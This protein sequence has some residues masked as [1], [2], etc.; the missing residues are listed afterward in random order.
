MIEIKRRRM[1]AKKS[2]VTTFSST[3]R[4][5]ASRLLEQGTNSDVFSSVHPRASTVSCG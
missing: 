3:N 4:A 2:G 5:A 1:D